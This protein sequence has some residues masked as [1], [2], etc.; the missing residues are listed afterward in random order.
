MSDST[1]KYENTLQQYKKLVLLAGFASVGV[2]VLFIIIKVAVWIISSST[3]IFASLTDSIFDLLASLV[4]LLALRFSLTPPDKEHRF[5]HFKSQALAS[6]AQAAFIGGSSLLLVF[7]GIER[8]ITPQE[9]VHVDFAIIVSV[10][11]IFFTLLLVLFQTYV[12]NRTKSEAIGADRLHY[13]SDISLNIGVI[14][15]LV[16]DSYGYKWADGL[17]AA[18][19]GLYILKGAYEIGIRAIQTLLDKSLGPRSLAKIVN[20]INKIE[21]VK[22]IHDLKTHRAGPMVFIQGHIVMD[23]NLSLKNAHDIVNKVENS[24]KIE[25]PDVEFSFHMEPDQIATYESVQFVDHTQVSENG[26]EK[27]TTIQK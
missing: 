14:L 10:V 11:S 27:V 1:Q 24:I 23:G 8:C 15:A 25:F 22:S 20:H 26:E 7:H 21:G 9:L 2:A 12:F 19:I 6:L 5:G 13:L 4:N 3:V 17:F 16:L 18:L